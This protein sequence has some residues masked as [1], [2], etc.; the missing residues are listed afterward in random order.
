MNYLDIA[1]LI[2]LLLAAWQGYRRGVLRTLAG[3]ASYLVGLVAAWRYS[4]ALA[5]WLDRQFALRAVLAR[6]WQ[7]SLPAPET[8]V[9]PGVHLPALASAGGAGPTGEAA[10][11]V[12]TALAFVILLVV[13][14]VVVRWLAGLL[15]GLLGHTPLGAVNRLAGLVVGAAV[16]VL[17]LGTVLS[18]VAI[19]L[20]PDTGGMAQAMASSTVAPY[21]MRGYT[22][23]A[24]QLAALTGG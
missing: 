10:A 23:L 15:T 11:F 12:V 18:L 4:P 6:W 22:F 1:L 19:I 2:M 8:P 16:A 7:E 14:V 9:L 21:L 13:V 24:G 20:P 17:V 5:T 3:M